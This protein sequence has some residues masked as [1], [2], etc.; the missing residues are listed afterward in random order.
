MVNHSARGGHRGSVPW[1]AVAALSVPEIL[2][3][4]ESANGNRRFAAIRQ[5]E[6]YHKS[7]PR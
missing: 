3:A 6:Q 5:Q 4:G 2:S 7:A 1:P